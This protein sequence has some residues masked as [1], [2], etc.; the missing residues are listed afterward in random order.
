MLA[1]NIQTDALVLCPTFELLGFLFKKTLITGFRFAQV[2][3][4]QGLKVSFQLLCMMNSRLPL[5]FVTPQPQQTL[6][7]TLIQQLLLIR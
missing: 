5:L 1:A 7:G 6:A 3:S 4:A 2:A